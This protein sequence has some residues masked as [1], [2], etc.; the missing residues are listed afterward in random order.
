MDT[1]SASR[2]CRVAILVGVALIGCGGEPGPSQPACVPSCVDPN[3]C[4]NSC[5]GLTCP[6][7]AGDVCDPGGACRACVA[8]ACQAA[9]TACFDEC[10]NADTTCAKQC[11]DPA[12]CADDCGVSNPTL[13]AGAECDPS[14]PG[15]CLDTCGQYAARCC[16]VATTCATVSIC[17]DNCGNYDPYACAG[18]ACGSACQDTCGNPDPNCWAACVDPTSCVDDCGNFNA[19]ACGGAAIC[20]PLN[21]GF[22]TCGNVQDACD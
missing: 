16:C 6:C 14:Y 12:H 5:G 1:N 22:D 11:G 19:T 8:G 2:F 20:D 15:G 21:R 3:S 7:P 9:P 13:C 10:G 4:R 17:A 18:L